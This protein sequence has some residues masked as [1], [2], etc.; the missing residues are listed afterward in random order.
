MFSHGPAEKEADLV[1]ADAGI[2]P[3]VKDS[4]FLAYRISEAVAV[5]RFHGF[6]VE[7]EE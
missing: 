5:L 1:L 4:Y 2:T 6:E 3:S 7:V